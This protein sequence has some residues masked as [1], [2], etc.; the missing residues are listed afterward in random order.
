VSPPVYDEGILTLDPQGFREGVKTCLTTI[1]PQG[2]I[3][4]AWSQSI[5]GDFAASGG[6]TYEL[7]GLKLDGFFMYSALSR[8]NIMKWAQTRC[9]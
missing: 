1:E 8:S 9:K 3:E 5:I 4:Q 6:G 2:C 7:T